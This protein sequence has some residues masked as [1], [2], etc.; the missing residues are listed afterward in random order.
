MLQ[1]PDEINAVILEPLNVSSKN[2]IIFPINDNTRDKAGGSHWSLLVFSRP[3]GKFFHFDSAGSMNFHV[4]SSFVRI[5]KACLKMTQEEGECVQVDCLQQNNSYDCGIFVL[6]HIDH[7]CKIIMRHN[8]LSNMPTKI[9]FGA[10]N[11]KR[12]EILQIATGLGANVKTN[13]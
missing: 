2:F 5:L 7:V 10:V 6:C 3:E 4:C 1:N 9:P 13:L 8:R 11:V 12:Q